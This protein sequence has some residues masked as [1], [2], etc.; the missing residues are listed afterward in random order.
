MVDLGMGQEAWFPS[1]AG[2]LRWLLFSMD[3]THV[4]MC[5]APVGFG[6]RLKAF[7]FLSQRYLFSA[8]E[9]TRG[10][11]LRITSLLRRNGAQPL[12]LAEGPKGK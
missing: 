9:E 7:L 1:A 3:K 12:L 8:R 6:W 5:G 2:K 10:K 11:L 4:R